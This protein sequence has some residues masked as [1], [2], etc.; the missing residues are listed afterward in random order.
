MT[1]STHSGTN[2]AKAEISLFTLKNFT[3][4]VNFLKRRSMPIRFLFGIIA[5]YLWLVI[6]LLFV[7]LLVDKDFVLFNSWTYSFTLIECIK[8]EFKYWTSATCLFMILNFICLTLWAIKGKIKFFIL[9]VL[10]S[11]YFSALISLICRLS[12][13]RN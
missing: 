11:T 6:I 3:N 9:S 8:T 13:W 10:C 12:V 1:G 2:M 5:G 7:T 4:V